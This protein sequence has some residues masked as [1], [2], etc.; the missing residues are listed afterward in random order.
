[1]TI[2][3]RSII[4]APTFTRASM[5]PELISRFEPVAGELP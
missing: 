2:S 5:P 1:M 3:A 4:A